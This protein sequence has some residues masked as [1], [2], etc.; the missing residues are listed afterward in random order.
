MKK[1]S[2]KSKQR[3]Q[4]LTGEE[5][6]RLD[7]FLETT[8]GALP[9]VQAH[10]LISAMASTPSPSLGPSAWLSK[11]HGDHEFATEEE[12]QELSL[13]I[14]RLYNQIVNDLNNGYFSGP[15][16]PDDVRTWCRGY[17]AGVGLDKQWQQNDE[18][19]AMTLPLGLLADEQGVTG[20][21]DNHGDDG[22]RLAQA[23]QEL[24]N[25]VLQIHQHWNE[26]RKQTL[27]PTFN[28]A[29]APEP[30]KKEKVGRNE[31]CP[32][33]SGKKYKKCCGG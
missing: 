4:P 25:S 30:E 6:G 14:T 31:K 7:Q 19:M 20:Q 24:P 26:W 17:M 32:C 3:I 2:Q 16:D 13:L 5:M 8:D 12:G 23:V 21:G 1:K 11:V 15:E 27:V 29:R 22:A 9:M 28:Q 33:G 18:A 10:G